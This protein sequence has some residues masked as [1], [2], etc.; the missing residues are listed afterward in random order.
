MF[1][2][3][4]TFHSWFR[5]SIDAVFSRTLPFHFR[6]RLV[7]L[8]PISVLTYSIASFPWLFSR[9]FK[10][11]YLPITST[12]SLRVLV[13]KK[14]SPTASTKLRPLHVDIHGGAFIG[15]LPESDAH[16]CDRLAEQ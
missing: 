11:Q 2:L 15:G 12:R 5:P 1:S 6:W 8:Q 10:V 7:V 13:F 4:H 16:F 14:P 9:A 3:A